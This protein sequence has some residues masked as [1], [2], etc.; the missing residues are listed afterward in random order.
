MQYIMNVLDPIQLMEQ[1]K[2]GNTDAFGELYKQYLVPVYRYIYLRIPHRQT[3]E[4]LAQVV[5]IKVFESLPRYVAV[6]SAPLAYFFTV[7]RNTVIDHVRKKKP[8]FLDDHPE[9]EN[10]LQDT[11]KSAEQTL[12]IEQDM[13]RVLAGIK[14]L[15]Q[16]QQEVIILK[17]FSELKNSEVAEVLGKSEEAVR[18]LQCRAL[19]ILRQQLTPDSKNNA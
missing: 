8:E 4:D 15:T 6:H 5:F 1:A 16:E 19:K 18:Q 10:T 17:F 2:A 11:N 13:N 7:A 12:I 9:L 3:A 14:T